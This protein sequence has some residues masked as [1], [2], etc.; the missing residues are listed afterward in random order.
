MRL[1]YDKIPVII[2]Q[3]SLTILL[4]KEYGLRLG[5][6]NGDFL[7]CRVDEGRLILE[8]AKR[9]LERPPSWGD[10]T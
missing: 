2:G 3:R 9:S 1:A 7:S 5:L 10:E 6:A 8:K 4:D